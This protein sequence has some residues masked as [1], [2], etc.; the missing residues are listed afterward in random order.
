M[1]IFPTLNDVYSNGYLGNGIFLDLQSYNVPWKD[2]NINASL[3]MLYYSK[4]GDK[5]VS[6]LV[7]RFIIDDE[8]PEQNQDSIAEAAFTLFQSKWDKLYSTLFVEYNPIENYRMTESESIDRD[9]ATS[10]TNTGTISDVGSNSNNAGLYGFNSSQSVPSDTVSGSDQS[11][12]TQNLANSQTVDEGIERTMTRSGN[13]GVTT[14]QQLLQSEIEL[15]EWNF[16]EQVFRDLDSV[17]TLKI[18]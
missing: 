6:S 14:S 12:Q 11:T 10:G 8:L 18:Y 13:I 3:D 2:E 16:F 5:K 4:S 17:L 9:S 7:R 1:K 15:W